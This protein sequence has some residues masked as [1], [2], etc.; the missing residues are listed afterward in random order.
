M[1]LTKI[2][3]HMSHILFKDPQWVIGGPEVR[4]VPKHYPVSEHVRRENKTHDKKI[5]LSGVVLKPL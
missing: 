5:I 2:K 3:L 4:L 1:I